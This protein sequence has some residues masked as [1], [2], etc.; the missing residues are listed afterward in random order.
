MASFGAVESVLWIPCA[1]VGAPGV[2]PAVVVQS[3]LPVFL[4]ILFGAAMR[5]L[6]VVRAGQ[7]AEVMHVT[8]HVLYPCFILDRM[9]G[10]ELLHRPDVVAWGFG[11]GFLLPVAGITLGWLSG[12]LLGYRH[13]TGLRTFALT[14]G[15]QNYG[16]TAVPVVMALWP[17]AKNVLGMLFVHNFGMEMAM[18]SVGVM[19]MSGDRG[20]SWRYLLNGPAVAVVAGLLMVWSG[21][22][23][24][25]A[26][27]PVREAIHLLG[28]GAFP[29]AIFLIGSIIMELVGKERL[30]L[31]AAVGGSVVRLVLCGGMIL[32]AARF[33]PVVT[34]MRQ[35]LLVQAAMPA[36]MTPIL[37]AKLYADRPAVAVQIVVVTTIACL[38]TLPL[39]IALGWRWLGL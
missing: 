23:H 10:S 34:E 9:L 8:I 12:R 27:G 4:L 26:G 28:S 1:A 32:A 24:W 6:R 29:L 31:R 14:S 3:V 18:W 11:L 22:D 2:S 25:L 17:E 39:V 19:M 36:A 20:I 13:D 35:V 5:R 21:T 15:T 37:L 7:E 16:F 38:G 33:L 30:S